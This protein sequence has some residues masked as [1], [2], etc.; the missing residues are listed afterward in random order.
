MKIWLHW[1]CQ[2]NIS[3]HIWCSWRNLIH[4]HRDLCFQMVLFSSASHISLQK[5]S[6]SSVCSSS[7]WR[8][9]KYSWIEVWRLDTW[10]QGVQ[11]KHSIQLLEKGQSSVL[12]VKRIK[13][14]KETFLYLDTLFLMLQSHLIVNWSIFLYDQWFLCKI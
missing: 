6:L 7:E 10:L 12:H 13:Q 14:K 4:L 5:M 1:M 11:E 2:E 9:I 8:K 3:F